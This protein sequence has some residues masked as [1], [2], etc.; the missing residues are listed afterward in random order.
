M[1]IYITTDTQ[2][3][4]DRWI[5]E[6]CLR[7]WESKRL[8]ITDIISLA[9]CCSNPIWLSFLCET[10]KKTYWRV[11]FNQTLL[12][13]NDFH[14]TTHCPSEE[15][16]VYTFKKMTIPTLA[17][18]KS[19]NHESEFERKPEEYSDEWHYGIDGSVYGFTDVC[20][21]MLVMLK[22]CRVGECV[23]LG[24]ECVSDGS[25]LGVIFYIWVNKWHIYKLIGLTCNTSEQVRSTPT[26]LCPSTELLILRI[27]SNPKNIM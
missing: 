13:T 24:G 15:S 21:I 6:Y 12:V 5:F 10:Q 11:I 8:R 18:L 1:F 25:S 20:W 3:S 9:S 4:L 26:K 17:L 23:E 7:K 22:C 16:G 19:Q 27:R 14:W 2:I